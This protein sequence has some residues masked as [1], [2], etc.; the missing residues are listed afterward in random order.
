MA[1][2]VFCSLHGRKFVKGVSVVRN[3]VL[4]HFCRSC[5]RHRRDEVEAVMT[6][7]A[8]PKKDAAAKRAIA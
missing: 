8:G 7:I 5:W 6:K 1:H 4:L 2:A 3:F